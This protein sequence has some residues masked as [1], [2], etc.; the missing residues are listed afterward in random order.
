MASQGFTMI[1][2][3][4]PIIRDWP[5]LKALH[6][7]LGNPFWLEFEKLAQNMVN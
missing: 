5:F 6:A 3:Y 2:I 7:R 1:A 4:Y